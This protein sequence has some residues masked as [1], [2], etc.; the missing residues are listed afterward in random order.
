MK[1][2]RKGEKTKKKEDKTPPQKKD[3]NN[4]VF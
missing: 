3:K 1:D 4:D 2:G